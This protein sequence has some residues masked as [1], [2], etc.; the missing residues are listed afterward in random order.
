MGDYCESG[1]TIQVEHQD[2]PAVR[3]FDMFQGVRGGA[4]RPRS[5][6]Q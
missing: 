3:L 1:Q 5:R 4:D 6:T 2:V